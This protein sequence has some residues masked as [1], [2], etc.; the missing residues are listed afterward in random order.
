MACVP[1]LVSVNVAREC[2]FSPADVNWNYTC[3]VT[4]EMPALERRPGRT[5][6]DVRAPYRAIHLDR[7]G[8]VVLSLERSSSARIRSAPMVPP[9]A[10]QMRTCQSFVSDFNRD[11]DDSNGSTTTDLLN[12]FHVSISAL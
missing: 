10:V 3:V 11:A 8:R 4:R 5:G 9:D 2:A 6:H 7:Q 1:A 12:T